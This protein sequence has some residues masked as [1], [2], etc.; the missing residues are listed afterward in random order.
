MESIEN[1]LSCLDRKL[2]DRTRHACND[3][4]LFSLLQSEWFSIPG[5][6][7]ITLVRSM[8]TRVAKLDL[9]EGTHQVLA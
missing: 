7:Y 6:Y 3:D 9:N 2:H 5:K 4:E 8:P 1:A